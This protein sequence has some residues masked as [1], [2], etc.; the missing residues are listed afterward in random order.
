MLPQWWVDKSGVQKRVRDIVD[1]RCVSAHCYAHRLNLVVVNAAHGVEQADDFFLIYGG[2]LQIL[3]CFFASLWQICAGTEE[4]YFESDGNS[5]T[6]RC[7]MCMP[8]CSSPVIWVSILMP[9][10]CLE[11]SC[12]KV[13]W[14]FWSSIGFWIF[15]HDLL[16]VLLLAVFDD[17]LG[18]TKPL[19][20]SYRQNNRLCAHLL[21]M[22]F[23]S[24]SNRSQ[25]IPII[26]NFKYS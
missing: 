1:T 6:F 19:L 13:K 21:I 10:R 2:N 15:A 12:R 11:N 4:S 7:K 18:L 3:L 8:S 16:F 26:T 20:T 23:I 14:L 5:K 22:I 25:C 9:H 17:I 24:H